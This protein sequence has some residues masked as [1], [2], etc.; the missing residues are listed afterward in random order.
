M[1]VFFNHLAKCGGSTINAIAKEEYG[2]DFHRLSPSTET[3][4]L[5]EWLS[6]KKCFITSEMNFAKVENILLLL[7][8]QKLIRIILSRDPVERFISFCA[9]STRDS[10]GK[11]EP[12]TG[13]W[14]MEDIIKQPMSANA[15]M[16]SC[17]SRMQHILEDKDNSLKLLGEDSR[18]TF[19]I[20]SQWM[21]ASFQS[22]FD[23]NEG[24]LT[25]VGIRNQRAHICHWRSQPNV[26]SQ[27]NRFLI[28]FY[29]AWGTTDDIPLFIKT[30]SKTG[31]FSSERAENE[32][33][34]KNSSKKAQESKQKLFEISEDLIAEYYAMLPE[35]FWFHDICSQLASQ[36][37]E[38]L[39]P[40]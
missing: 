2:E 4:E 11:D 30:L 35:E 14:G 19:S 8:D 23:F 39:K 26:T 7:N 24:K 15:W 20:Y 10:L 1:R 36:R 32:I 21:L 5:N 34:I 33:E 22:H 18:W 17:L 6:K 13:F 25:P 38:H 16:R 27:I 9:H 29:S 28:Q 3:D 40:K 12:G 37:W 31:I